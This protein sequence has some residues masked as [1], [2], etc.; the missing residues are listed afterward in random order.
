MGGMPKGHPPMGGG[1][2]AGGAGHGMGAGST[3]IT[4]EQAAEALTQL[5]FAWTA[6]EG[7]EFGAPANNMRIAQYAIGSD[8][9]CVLFAGI[10]G[11]DQQNIDRWVGFF[12]QPDGSPSADA[13]KITDGDHDGFRIKAVSITGT[14]AG[15]GMPGQGG[16]TGD[17]LRGLLG[18]CITTPEGVVLH[19][20]MQGPA[21]S[22]KAAQPAFD[23]WLKSFRAQTPAK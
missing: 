16:P 2:E 7:W 21:D 19:A 4:K 8:V 23:A 14:V 12:T 3:G 13:A 5:P 11:T 17:Q 15:R 6:P 9:E 18:A 22:V 10:L 1:T 20:K